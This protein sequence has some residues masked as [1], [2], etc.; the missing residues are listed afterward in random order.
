MREPHV[1]IT[2]DLHSCYD[3]IVHNVAGLV[4]QKHG[5]QDSPIQ[6]L[7]DTLR[8]SVNNVR[9]AYGDSDRSYKSEDVPFQGTG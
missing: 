4:C 5:V 8:N 9:T 7:V 6:M 3:R 2:T 1:M